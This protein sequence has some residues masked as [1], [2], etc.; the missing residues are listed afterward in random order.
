MLR[1]GLRQ[2]RVVGIVYLLQFGLALTVGM[3]ADHVLEASIG[4]SLALKQL[5]EGYDHTVITDFLKVHGASITPLIGQVRWLLLFWLVFSV[6]LNAGLMTCAVSPEKNKP[7]DFWTGA[8]EQFLPFL[9]IACFF[10]ALALLWTVA[11]LLPLGLRLQPMLQA[12]HTEQYALG[13]LAGMMSLYLLGLLVL[14]AWSLCV[15]VA[16]LRGGGR[17]AQS[18]RQG[19]RLF[20]Q[21]KSRLVKLIGVFLLLQACLFGLYWYAESQ[22]GMV[23]IA[24]IGLFFMFQQALAFSRIMVRQMLYVGAGAIS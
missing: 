7:R 24:T 6:F 3:Q 17:F 23:S 14:F 10:I 11:I 18:L 15:R 19:S 9:R 5:M 21:Q 13:F 12:Y 8:A 1:V 22:W 4:R 16:R 2:W 20:W